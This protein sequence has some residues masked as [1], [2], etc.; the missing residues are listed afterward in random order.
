[1]SGR[2]CSEG[3]HSRT[4][5]SLKV[6]KTHLV[7]TA[8]VGRKVAVDKCGRAQI[9]MSFTYHARDLEFHTADVAV[10]ARDHW[11]TPWL[12]TAVYTTLAKKGYL[13]YY[14]FTTSTFSATRCNGLCYT[15]PYLFLCTISMHSSLYYRCLSPIGAFLF[16]CVCPLLDP[17]CIDSLMN[18]AYSLEVF[19]KFTIALIQHL[20]IAYYV[21][22]SKT[23]KGTEYGT[24]NKEKNPCSLGVCILR[25]TQ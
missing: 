13:K 18:T 21:L 14:S 22:S 7:P 9:M 1:M 17:K 20:L 10:C 15:N 2:P 25:V 24:V 3:E 5:K 16:T 19:N 4:R 6:L 8:L 12:Y 23:A 11:Y